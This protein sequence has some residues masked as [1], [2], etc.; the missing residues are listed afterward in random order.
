MVV[1]QKADFV[2]SIDHILASLN[3]QRN[4]A[5]SVSSYNQVALVLSNSDCVATLPS[6]LLNR[7]ESSLDLIDVPF[8]IPTFELGTCVGGQPIITRLYV[9]CL[10][11]L[12]PQL[13]LN[14]VECLLS[15]EKVYELIGISIR[16][17]LIDS[18]YPNFLGFTFKRAFICI[19]LFK[20]CIFN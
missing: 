2:T 4:V 9:S 5:V 3:C 13:S 20:V 12:T 14:I 1:S 15:S 17:K 7:Y 6:Q 16:L 10:S 11:V 8:D 19:I 18:S